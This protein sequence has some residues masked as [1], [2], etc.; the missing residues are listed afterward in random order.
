MH[1]MNKM[2]NEEEPNH[3]GNI[4]SHSQKWQ[5]LELQIWQVTSGVLQNIMNF[6]CDQANWLFNRLEVEAGQSAGDH[7]V[8]IAHGGSSRQ[9]CGRAWGND[10]M[11]CYASDL[12]SVHEL[13]ILVQ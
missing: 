10:E 12:Q 8:A 9:H 2:Q 5:E 4:I 6:I 11:I 1:D 13:S 7:G 3:E